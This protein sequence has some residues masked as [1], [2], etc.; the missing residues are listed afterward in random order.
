MW[1]KRAENGIKL[2]Q[3]IYKKQKVNLEQKTIKL[4][5]RQKDKRAEKEAESNW[6]QAKKKEK[7]R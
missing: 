7:K 1:L 3:M 4:K 6:D 5:F 2:K